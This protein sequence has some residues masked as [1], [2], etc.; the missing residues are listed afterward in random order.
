VFEEL[1]VSNNIPSSFRGILKKT[2]AA[3]VLRVRRII[4][5][6]RLM[7][8]LPVFDFETDSP[9]DVDITL[10]PG[11]HP[12]QTALPFSKILTLQP[13]IAGESAKN[14]DPKAVPM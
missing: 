4:L 1:F 8:F 9:T 7:T 2:Y 11:V 14:A 5:L 3:L 13:L 12:V 10:L 6:D